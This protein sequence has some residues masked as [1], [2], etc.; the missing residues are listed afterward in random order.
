VAELRFAEVQAYLVVRL[1]ER[2]WLLVGLAAELAA[3]PR[4]VRRL[5]QQAGSFALAAAEG[6]V[7]QVMKP[8]WA[9][10]PVG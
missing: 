6:S 5:T 4:T 7:V 2:E 8:S 1:V 3:D 9:G 10:E